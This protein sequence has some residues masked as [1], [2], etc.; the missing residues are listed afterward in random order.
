M[1]RGFMV[2]L[3]A[4]GAL[5]TALVPAVASAGSA[6]RP[7]LTAA[8]ARTVANVAVKARLGGAGTLGAL[9]C[10]RG[11]ARVFNCA[12][13]GRMTGG[14]GDS[15]EHP[16]RAS[17]RV[18]MTCTRRKRCTT[19]ATVQLTHAPAPNDNAPGDPSEHEHH[20]H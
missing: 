16:F 19:R 8:K 3:V 18:V 9:S 11:S 20:H 1:V 13:S 12:G 17:A 10:R 4:L 14:G 2:M 6:A 7:T 5:G 15:A